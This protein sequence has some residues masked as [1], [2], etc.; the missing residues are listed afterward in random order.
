[1][2]ET[3]HMPDDSRIPA[4][5]Q[6][7]DWKPYEPG[8][9]HYDGQLLLCAVPVHNNRHMRKGQ[10]VYEFS[11]VRIECDEHYL[12]LVV[13]GDRWGWELDCIDYFVEIK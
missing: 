7:L 13:E 2:P 3:E 5:L 9:E 10:W 4:T 6:S 12:H 11:I 1:M 8:M